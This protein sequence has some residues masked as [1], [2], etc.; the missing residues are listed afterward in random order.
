[1]TSVQKNRIEEI[2]NK[3]RI[4]PDLITPAEKDEYIYLL[5][6]INKGGKLS[7]R[8]RKNKKRRSRRR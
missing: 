5:Q 4:S 7:K 1:M 8:K 3:N 6:Q 2:E